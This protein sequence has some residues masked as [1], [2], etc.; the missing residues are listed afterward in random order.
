MHQSLGIQRWE[1]DYSLAKA[2]QFSSIDRLSSDQL[3][4]VLGKGANEWALPRSSD[5]FAANAAPLRS[6]RR[7]SGENFSG[8]SADRLAGER[9]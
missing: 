7:E 9:T 6:D 2:D 8:L 4:L 5:N 1:R 3:H